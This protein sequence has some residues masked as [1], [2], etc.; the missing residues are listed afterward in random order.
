M[1]KHT[2]INRATEDVLK[3]RQFFTHIGFEINEQFSDESGFCVVVNETTF[4]MV[5]N[6]EKFKGFTHA[7]LPNSD[8]ATQMILT[9]Q[10]ESM[11]E[12]DDFICK[13]LEAHGTEFG[14]A[15]DDDFMYYRSFK[16]LD[17]HHFEVFYFKR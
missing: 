9:F 10:L 16:D 13:V 6:K 4:L 1:I 7:D 11:Q 8:K 17:G 12:V 5:M 15:H 3:A 14:E 2:F